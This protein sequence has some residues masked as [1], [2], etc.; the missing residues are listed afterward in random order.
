M[1]VGGHDLPQVGTVTMDQVMVD[2][3][4]TDVEVGQVATLLGDRYTVADI[5]LYAYTHVADQGGF[6]LAGYPGVRAWI[7][8]FP[9]LTG[10]AAFGGRLRDHDGRRA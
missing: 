10:Y 6:D 3:G 1:R 5:S 9:G 8:R 7:E 4:E 2:V